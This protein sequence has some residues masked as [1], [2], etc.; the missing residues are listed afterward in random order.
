MVLNKG[1]TYESGVVLTVLRIEGPLHHSREN[2]L[3]PLEVAGTYE[4]RLRVG[5]E[6]YL[7]RNGRKARGQQYFDWKLAL[8]TSYKCANLDDKSILRP[9]STMRFIFIPEQNCSSRVGQ[10]ESLTRLSKSSTWYFTS[11]L[12]SDALTHSCH[13]LQTEEE[14]RL[15]W[16]KPLADTAALIII[17]NNR[18]FLK[19]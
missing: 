16:M 4:F 11:M 1:I 8:H 19:N 18:H 2:D 14:C 6:E 3:C 13:S 12:L 15:G 5:L 7:G 10:K 17:S 9:L